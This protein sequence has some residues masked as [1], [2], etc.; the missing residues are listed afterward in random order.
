MSALSR[1]ALAGAVLALALP[2]VAAAA[3]TVVVSDVAGDAT[4]V[5]VESSPL[6]SE[7]SLDILTGDVELVG[8]TLVLGMNVTDLTELP[9]TGS[10]GRNIRMSFVGGG[11]ALQARAFQTPAGESAGISY[12]DPG[13]GLYRSVPC[14]GCTVEFDE[15]GDRIE[16]ALPMA[17]VN[18]AAQAAGGRAF[19]SGDFITGF[20]DIAQRFVGSPTGSGLTP[21][22]D[23]GYGNGTKYQLP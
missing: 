9:P 11:A 14:T 23:I 8:E 12:E 22:A 6:P 20:Q 7:P 4:G 17:T 2:S 16:V 1:G 15:Q 18:A 5:I 13:T 3:P 21:T 10:V 19:Q